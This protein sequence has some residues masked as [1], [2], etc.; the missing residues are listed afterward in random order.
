MTGGEEAHEYVN[1]PTRQFIVDNG[2]LEVL[3]SR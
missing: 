2:V 3:T 1:A